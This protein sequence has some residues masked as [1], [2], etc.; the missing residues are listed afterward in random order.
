MIKLEN[1]AKVYRMGEVEVYALRGVSLTIKPGEMVSI[2]G[3]SGSGKSTLLHI[4]GCLDRPSSG[5]YILDGVDVSRLSDDKLAE[6]RNKK[7]GFVF[8]EFNLLSRATALANVELPLIYGGGGQKDQKAMEALERVGLRE[9]AKHKPTEL[10]GGEQQRV[11]IARALVNKPSIIFAD[12]PTGNLDSVATKE[13]V[14]VFKKLNKDGI[15]IVVVT[16]EADIAAQTK[17]VIRL[18]DGEIVSQ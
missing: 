11:A 5:R 14:S 4:L 18:R 10:S 12:E 8:Q 16:H 7:F 3:A 9:R 13:I 6:M 17:R 2:V 1:I 15:T